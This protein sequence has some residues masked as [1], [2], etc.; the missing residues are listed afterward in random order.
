MSVKPIK[1]S[2]CGT[3]YLVSIHYLLC[4]STLLITKVLRPDLCLLQ[5]CPRSLPVLRRWSA[6]R[7][8]PF[9]FN[10]GIIDPSENW[11]YR[12]G[13]GRRKFRVVKVCFWFIILP[14]GQFDGSNM[15][16]R[17]CICFYL[18]STSWKIPKID[19]ALNISS[20]FASMH[21][22]ISLD[23]STY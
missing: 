3:R 11:M 21:W 17:Y 22:E 2:F 10:S 13:W 1:L 9:H 7:T 8:S 14:Y 6:T 16:L 19:Y 5:R 15:E 20:S 12:Y 23:W 18:R 4:T